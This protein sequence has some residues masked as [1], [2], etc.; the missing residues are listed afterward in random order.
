MDVVGNRPV[1]KASL[2]DKANKCL[3]NLCGGCK[4]KGNSVYNNESRVLTSLGGLILDIRIKVYN[5]FYYVFLF[6]G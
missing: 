5:S 1:N 3:V 6:T 4:G 2:R